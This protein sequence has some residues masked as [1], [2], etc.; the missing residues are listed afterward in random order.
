MTTSKQKKKNKQKVFKFLWEKADRKV[1]HSTFTKLHAEKQ[2]DWNNS[3]TDEKLDHF[4]ILL[5]ET[6]EK[7]VPKRL[8][9]LNGFKKKASPKVRNLIKISKLKYR[10]WD[11]EGRPRNGHKLFIERKEAKRTL[12]RQQRK[13]SAIE[14]QQ[15]LEKLE[16]DPMT[17][18]FFN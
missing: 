2:F 8:I 7:T 12:R 13:E 5:L 3:Q 4:N 10:A 1:F 15:F 9:K 11:I 17:R 16:S 6:A 18:H 14:R